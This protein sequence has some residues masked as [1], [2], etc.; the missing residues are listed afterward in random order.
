MMILFI[1]GGEAI[2]TK[3][4]PRTHSRLILEVTKGPRISS[5]ELHATLG[6]LNVRV[7]DSTKKETVQK[8]HLWERSTAKKQNKNEFLYGTFVLFQSTKR[9]V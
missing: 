3:I 5:K 6:S 4:P 7:Y 2:Q 1:K 8:W 9:F